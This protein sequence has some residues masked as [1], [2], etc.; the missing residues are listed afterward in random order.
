[1]RASSAPRDRTVLD[2]SFPASY[3]W[4]TVPSLLVVATVPVT[5]KAFLLPYAAHFRGKGWRVEAAACGVSSDPVCAEA[6]DAVHDVPWQRTLRDLRGLFMGPRIVHA[7]VS[8]EAYDIVHVHTPIASALTRIAIRKVRSTGTTRVI[9]T[10]HGFH[11]HPHGRWASNLAYL[12]AEVIA[13]RWTDYLVVINEYDETMARRYM[14]L[15][16]ARI[17]RMPGIGIDVSAYSTAAL[18][19]SAIASVRGEIGLTESDVLFV[20]VGELSPE[21]RH[22]DLIEAMKRIDDDRIHLAIVGDGP[23]RDSLHQSTRKLRLAR[24]VHFLGYR[25]DVPVLLAAAHGFVFPSQREGLPRS[26]MEAMCMGLPVIGAD[27]RGTRD[28]ISE[29]GG[30]LHPV[31]DTEAIAE[32]MRTVA[33]DADLRSRLAE[34]ARA[35]VSRYAIENLL[36]MHEE[37]YEAALRR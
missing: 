33:A 7:L 11:F 2:S 21:K 20:A 17:V 19:E 16:A 37:L 26:V 1:M 30:I 29:G 28:L 27:I 12:A 14:R 23:L 36:S 22:A 35:Q 15:P 8:A 25:R 13:S 10:A 6:F 32:A 24:R 34:E 3:T 31:G 9:Y 4:P 5:L 18:D